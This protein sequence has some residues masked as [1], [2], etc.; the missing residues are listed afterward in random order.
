MV[1]SLLRGE[2]P[3]IVL[4]SNLNNQHFTLHAVLPVNY[5]LFKLCF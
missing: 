5:M 3:Q 4:L 1:L 2:K